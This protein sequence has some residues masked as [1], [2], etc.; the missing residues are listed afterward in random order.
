[1]RFFLDD[2]GHPEWGVE[3]NSPKLSIRLN[4]A[5]KQVE[6]RSNQIHLEISVSQTKVW[7]ET[8]LNFKDIIC[9]LGILDFNSNTNF[10]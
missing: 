5:L 4:H 2:I 3:I 7:L 9:A 1:M 8:K 6:E 10:H